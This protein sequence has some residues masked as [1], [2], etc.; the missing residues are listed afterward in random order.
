[1]EHVQRINQEVLRQINRQ[2]T[3]TASRFANALLAG[4]FRAIFD[5]EKGYEFSEPEVF[6][7]EYDPD[8]I[9]WPRLN[10]W[11]IGHL[12]LAIA[13]EEVLASRYQVFTEYD[14]VIVAD[15]S[16]S[17]MLDWWSMYGGETM[18]RTTPRPM[19]TRTIP[20]DRTK[21]CLM[22]YILA[23][24]LCA[25]RT[26]EFFSYVLLAGGGR[27]REYDSR[28]EPNLDEI[29]LNHIDEQYYQATQARRQESPMLVEALRRVAARKRR[30]I[31]LCLSDFTDTLAY[32]TQKTPRVAMRS[33]LLPL[34]QIAAHHRV[35]AMQIVDESEIDPPERQDSHFEVKNSPYANPECYPE[36]QS[37]SLS[38][39][40]L[41]KHRREVE[42]WKIALSRAFGRFGIKFDRIVAGREDELVDKRIYQL[43]ASTSAW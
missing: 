8:R 24:F 5:I 35:V 29:L 32:P 33:I 36:N 28:R 3:L 20:G 9:V 40:R 15:V 27:V 19:P 39:Y 42:A 12:A 26:N 22:K 34:T 10:Q 23:S 7:V 17:M 18:P 4:V 31:V 25:A 38:R 37:A 41:G 21:L 30:A 13:N 14:F 16:Q 2:I 11:Q 1:M 43:G 6:Q